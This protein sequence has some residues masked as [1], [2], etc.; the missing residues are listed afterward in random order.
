MKNRLQ[1][2]Y[3]EYMDEKDNMQECCDM[4]H[5][6]YMKNLAMEMVA[7]EMLM[8]SDIA[9][10][11][12]LRE[13]HHDKWHEALA[14]KNWKWIVFQRLQDEIKDAHMDIEAMTVAKEAGQEKVHAEMLAMAKQRIA[15]AEKLNAIYTAM[16]YTH[17]TMEEQQMWDKDYH[18]E[19]EKHKEN[20]A[21][22]Q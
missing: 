4:E 16:P 21:K 11:V 12:Q 14:H 18:M 8:K 9:K 5:Q 6:E 2:L 10:H 17:G 13:H 19:I 20:V 15:N 22:I 3:N 1:M 7:I